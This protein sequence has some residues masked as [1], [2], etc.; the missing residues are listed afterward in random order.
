MFDLFPMAI[1]VSLIMW[2]GCPIVAILIYISPIWDKISRQY[3]ESD[4]CED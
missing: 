1:I 4:D 3:D 2:I